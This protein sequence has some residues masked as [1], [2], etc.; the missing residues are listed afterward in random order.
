MRLVG[1]TKQN[2]NLQI[3]TLLAPRDLDHTDKKR[4]WLPQKSGA[5]DCGLRY[6]NLPS[7]I[8]LRT[9]KLFLSFP[10]K[11][12]SSWFERCCCFS[13]L[14]LQF[15]QAREGSALCSAKGLLQQRRHGGKKAE[16][17]AQSGL[18]LR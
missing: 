1:S 7:A 16:Y 5:I 18:I 12:H 11:V 4:D 3:F 2:K 6:E 17:S 13:N 14:P 9:F 8:L 15:I 10:S